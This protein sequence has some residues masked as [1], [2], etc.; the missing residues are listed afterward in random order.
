[1]PSNLFDPIEGVNFGR[2]HPDFLY[3]VE[4]DRQLADLLLHLAVLLL[5]VLRFLT[6]E[7]FSEHQ[8]SV[9]TFSVTVLIP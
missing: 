4:A 5:Q 3:S 7:N 6:T 1:M 2:I 8:K 9:Q